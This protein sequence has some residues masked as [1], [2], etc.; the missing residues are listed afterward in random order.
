MSIYNPGDEVTYRTL[1]GSERRGTV[2]R[3]IDGYEVLNQ[4]TI[5]RASREEPYYLIKESTTGRE[6]AYKW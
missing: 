2:Q 6:H 3:R 5:I 1:D 4:D